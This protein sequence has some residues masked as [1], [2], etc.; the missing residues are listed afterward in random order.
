MTIILVIIFLIQN[1][2]PS[3]D[4]KV[5]VEMSFDEIKKKSVIYNNS[6]QRYHN[7]MNECSFQLCLNNPALCDNK[8]QLIAMCRQKLDSEGYNYSKKSQ[9]RRCLVMDRQKRA[10]RMEELTADMTSL[11][12]RIKLLQK[13]RL[14]DEQLKQYLRA[15]AME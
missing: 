12:D 15:S 6:T 2:K 10:K 3:H 4:V 11:E 7:R 13:Q 14:R 1:E 9:D 5:V 8:E